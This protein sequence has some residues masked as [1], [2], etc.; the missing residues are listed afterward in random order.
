MHQYVETQMEEFE[1]ILSMFPD[2]EELSYDAQLKDE[3][4][5]Y[6]S[7]E[8][9]T[10][11][12]PETRLQYTIHFTVDG[13]I[14]ALEI[15]YPRQYPMETV[16]FVVHCPSLSREAMKRMVTELMCTAT[17]SDGEIIVLQLY[18]QMAEILEDC[19]VNAQ[20]T[21]QATEALDH[22]SITDEP[23][24][25]TL[26]RRAIYFHH[27]IAST[28]RRV[29][30]EWA[31]ELDLGGFSKIGWPG[32]VIVEGD[33]DAAQEYVRRLQ[34][35]RWKQ[36]VVRGEQTESGESIEAMRRLPRGFTEFPENG[37]SDAASLCREV[38][39]ED[40]FLSVMKI[41]RSEEREPSDSNGTDSGKSSKKAS[42]R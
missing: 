6:L 39:V 3:Y 37:M 36:M 4:E 27:I 17:G 26:G 33:E 23:K 16:E 24:Q 1:C 14:P 30:K 11:R 13:Q 2:D 18:Q 38:G 42:K 12:H 32:V 20:A 29:V 35:L 10:A 15:K 31:L 25:V 8:E 21:Q 19:L 5:N 40:L 22:L 9:N 41:Y 7:L 28:K 34:H